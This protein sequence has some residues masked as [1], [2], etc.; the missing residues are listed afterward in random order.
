MWRPETSKPFFQ[1]E[2]KSNDIDQ[3]LC[4]MH[5]TLCTELAEVWALSPDQ[6]WSSFLKPSGSCHTSYS[7]CGAFSF[8]FR[9]EDN[10]HDLVALCAN[11]LSDVRRVFVYIACLLVGGVFLFFF[12]ITCAQLLRSRKRSECDFVRVV[13]V[14]GEWML[15]HDTDLEH[16]VIFVCTYFLF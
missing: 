10:A 4:E 1:L 5:A 16:L 11:E 9:R 13:R 6:R 14:L 2:D 15:M 7:W 12:K 3:E 8:F